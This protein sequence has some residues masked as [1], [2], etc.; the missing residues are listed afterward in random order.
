MEESNIIVKILH[1][2]DWEGYK[3]LRLE[4]LLHEPLAFGSD[5]N[6]EKNLNHTD[7]QKRLADWVIYGAFNADILIGLL[8][9][10]PDT[11]LKFAHTA[12]VVGVHVL[13]AYE[14]KGICKILFAQMFQGLLERKI[15]KI[16]LMVTVVQIRAI[17]TYLALGFQIVGMAKSQLFYNGIYYDMYYMEKYV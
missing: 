7:W 11:S 15:L 14:K 12:S 17:S 2:N 8:S 16:S 5:Y 4:S 10:V 13:P 9:V 3:G 1:P 6:E